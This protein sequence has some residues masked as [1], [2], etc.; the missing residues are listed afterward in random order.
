M[1]VL[2]ALGL[3][4]ALGRYNPL[5][6]VLFKLVPGFGLFRVPARWLLLYA[7]GAAM[8]AGIGLQRVS[9]HVRK[10]A[11]GRSP[12]IRAFGQA[13]IALLLVLSLA[14]L[15]L[16]ARALPLT[17]PTAPGAFSS[18]RTAPAH[19]L[20]AQRQEIA[21]GRFLSLSH[22]L[23]DPGDLGEIQQIYQDQLS[24]EALYAYVVN[25][26]RQ[27]I[28]APN[29]PL[30]WQIYAV[31]GYDG[32]VLPLA[33]Y[34]HLQGLLL[35]EKD[36]LS[37]GRLREGLERIPPSRLLSVLGARYVITDKVHDVW[38]DDVFY[39]LAF[40]TALSTSTTPSVSRNDLPRFQA[41]GLG[42]VTHLEGARDVPDG[43]R[44]ARI[45]LTTAGGETL[46]Y[47]LRAG[48]ETS[49]GVYDEQV[50]HRRATAGRQW[51][52]SE[53]GT[54]VQGNDYVALYH[55]ANPHELAQIR[56]E[57]L[58]F[59]AGRLHLRGA[60]LIDERDGSN[61]PLI[62]SNDGHFARV[63]SGDVKIYEALDVLPRAYA[64]HHTRVIEEE[65]A[66]LA[67]MLD[68]GFDP[69]HTAI[70]AGGRELDGP[71][72]GK[73]AS[74]VTIL[75]YEPEEIVLQASLLSPG[76]VAL[77]DSWYPGWRATVDREPVP[78]E[79]ANLAFRAVYV[80]Q[81]THTVRW[82]Y[83]PQS[84]LWGLW[85]SAAALLAI[86]AALPALLLWRRRRPGPH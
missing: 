15:L 70:L 11:Q 54:V 86:A 49:E 48:P 5:Y 6:W 43:T 36:I 58:P 30:A 72:P 39:D 59:G 69:A 75:S 47:F 1:V 66:A 38:I 33:H 83:R 74:A 46:T 23:F 26:K 44:V 71:Q 13:M 41:T 24:P 84:Y 82:T 45:D 81:G 55:W 79:R 53:S 21:P 29:L 52:Q 78:I 61:V 32:G 37:D 17:H 77:S 4:L 60:S 16:A 7:F 35:D 12:F 85:I 28:L 40:D 27:E 80:P 64:V 50:Q 68:P 57:A 2:A 56:I 34:V 31:D 19:I 51:Q 3:F 9:T 25:V 20:A 22:T 73:A 10:H 62:L 76:Y 42:I 18:L 8:L 65:G 14:E 67:A 63:H